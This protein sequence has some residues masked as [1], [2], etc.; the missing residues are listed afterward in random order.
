MKI[1]KL[2]HWLYAI[3][4]LAPISAVGVTCLTHVFNKEV[5]EESETAVIEYMYETSNPQDS[6]I[7]GYVYKINATTTYEVLGD[8]KYLFD[9]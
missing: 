5:S 8:Y 6:I 3:L 1:S 9:H 4:M 7:T 2:F